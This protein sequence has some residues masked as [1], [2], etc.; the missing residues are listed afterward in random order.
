MNRDEI[1]KL[2]LEAL[3]DIAPDIDL[4][5]FDEQAHLQDEYD[6][7]SMDLL[8]LA[9]SVHERLGVDIPEQDYARMHS[10]AEL[11]DY[12]ETRA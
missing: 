3:S 9:T 6:L 2:V 1:R 8:D 7:D 11:L 4:D 10:V 12:L 5:G